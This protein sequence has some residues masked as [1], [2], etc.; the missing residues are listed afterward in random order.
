MEINMKDHQIKLLKPK[1]FTAVK[2][3]ISPK[4]RPATYGVSACALNSCLSA[5]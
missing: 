2:G 5:K 1:M 3:F 4:I